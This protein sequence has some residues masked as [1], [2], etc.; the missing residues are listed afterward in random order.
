MTKGSVAEGSVTKGSVTKGSVT[1]RWSAARRPAD[2]SKRLA[3]SGYSGKRARE[4]G[5]SVRPRGSGAR[6]RDSSVSGER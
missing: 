6:E 1:T 2:N 4:R 5:N 3:A